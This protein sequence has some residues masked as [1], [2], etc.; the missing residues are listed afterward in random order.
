MA[1]IRPIKDKT[2]EI[3]KYQ[4]TVFL[5]KD[6]ATGKQIT[7]SKTWRRPDGWSKKAIDRELN[8]VA[9]EF[10][11]KCKRGEILPRAM[12]KAKEREEIE[13]EKARQAEERRKPTFNQYVE[14]FIKE[15]AVT[16]APTTINTYERELK[17]FGKTFGDKKMADIDFL[18]IKGYFVELQSEGQNKY[19]GQPLKFRTIKSRYRILKG[20]FENAVENEVIEINPMQKLKPPKPRKD[21]VIKESDAFDETQV[22]YILACA[23]NE[24]VERQAMI[25]FALDSGCRA[26]EIVG[27]KW[28]DIDFTSGCVNIR[29]NVQYTSKKG[30][31]ISTPK[32]HRNREIKLNAPA[33]EKMKRWRIEQ[34][35]IFFKL[36]IKLSDFCFTRHNG[37]NMKPGDFTAYLKRFGNKYNIQNLHPHKCR[38]TMATISI[39]HNA[40]PVS[41]SKKIGH[42]TPATTLNIYAH[43]NEQAQLRAN[44]ILA[45]AIYTK[46]A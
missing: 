23:E 5:R 19:T 15:K 4:I 46:Q 22:R 2:G 17:E 42:A 10:E 26:G 20:F 11:T 3:T 38:H 12:Q 35:Q 1:S 6:P 29:R 30:I 34:A 33:L 13:Q 43:A 18:T 14:M 40:D 41:V 25:I 37:D 45:D 36:G 16:L 32:T 8:R 27:L 7:K 21:E 28:S 44:E 31:Y 24:P 39:S 9:G